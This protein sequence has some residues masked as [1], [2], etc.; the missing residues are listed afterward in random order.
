MKTTKVL[1]I[2]NFFKVNALFVADKVLRNGE[3]SG[4]DDD[5]NC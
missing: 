2:I 5:R 3:Y 1:K 4:Y